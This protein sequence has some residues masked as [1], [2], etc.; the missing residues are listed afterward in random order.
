LSDYTSAHSSLITGVV[1]GGFAVVLSGVLAMLCAVDVGVDLLAGRA[2]ALTP[3]LVGAGSALSAGMFALL[4]FSS[5]RTLLL[6]QR[7]NERGI[8]AWATLGEA[9]RTRT[10]VHKRYLFRL[11]LQVTPAGGPPFPVTSRWFFPIDMRPHH[12]PG[13]RVVVRMDPQDRTAVL[14]DWDATRP[15]WGLPPASD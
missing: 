6:W 1:L 10:R 7:V 13:A 12:R 4:G 15:L 5:L 3:A 8:L 11:S 9:E 2:P 14:V